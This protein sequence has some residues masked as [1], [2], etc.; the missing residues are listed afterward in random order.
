MNRVI[1]ACHFAALKHSDQRRKNTAASPYINHPIECANILSQAGITDPDIIISAISHD[2]IEDTKTTSDEL[3]QKFGDVVV[4]IVL[5][6]TDDKA[7]DKIERKKL[8]L[9][10]AK[11]ASNEAKLVK[12]ADKISNLSGLLNDP[13][14]S[15]PKEEIYGY[16][17]WS[18][19][20][21]Q[22]IRGI[23]TNL[24]NTLQQIFDNFGVSKLTEGELQT[25]LEKYY[26]V[27]DKS[28]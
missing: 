1:E 5:E 20:V 19:H 17:I 27:I 7:L 18:Y 24:D 11:D 4:G 14:A 21:C 12:A 10:H 15:W 23:N 28:E 2:L 22:G 8:Q 9:A 3:R 25:E 26:C 16:A 13:P 6:C